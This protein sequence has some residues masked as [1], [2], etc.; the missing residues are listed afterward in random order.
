MKRSNVELP[1]SMENKYAESEIL[2]NH[3]EMSGRLEPCIVV[4]EYNDILFYFYF[5]FD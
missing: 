1:S 5:F 3:I 2:H 4:L